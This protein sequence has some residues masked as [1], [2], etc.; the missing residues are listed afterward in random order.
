MGVDEAV[1]VAAGNAAL[2]P[3]LLQM[4]ARPI[5]AL[6]RHVGNGAIGR[7]AADFGR[8]DL[9]DTADTDVLDSS[10]IDAGNV[11]GAAINAIDDEGQVFAELVGEMLVDDA[12]DDRRR[13]RAVVNPEACRIAREAFRPQYLVHGLD[14]IA[15][16]AQFAQ[17]GL[18]L[19]AQLPAAWRLFRGK[20]H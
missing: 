13:G 8:S 7:T 16:L 12:A 3:G 18:Q 1:M 11:V 2:E 17:G 10:R 15:A 20:P 5:D 14:D 4:A 6:L 9:D 19:F